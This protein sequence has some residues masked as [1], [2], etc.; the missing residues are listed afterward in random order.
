MSLRSRISC[1]LRETLIGRSFTFAK[2]DTELQILQY[3]PLQSRRINF[4][5][6]NHS[7]LFN[8]RYSPWGRLNAECHIHIREFSPPFL[9]LFHSRFPFRTL[10]SQGTGLDL[11][12]RP[13]E[14]LCIF[15]TARI[16]RNAQCASGSSKKCIN[17]K[18]EF[19]V[20]LDQSTENLR[21]PAELAIPH[22][23]KKYFFFSVCIFFFALV[24][25]KGRGQVRWFPLTKDTVDTRMKKGKEK[26][27]GNKNIHPSPEGEDSLI[28]IFWREFSRFHCYRLWVEFSGEKLESRYKFNEEKA[29]T[30]IVSSLNRSSLAKGTFEISLRIVLNAGR[31]E[32]IFG[33]RHG[34]R[35]HDEYGS[36]RIKVQG[37]WAWD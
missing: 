32:A 6:G 17:S 21:I 3:Y 29:I 7:A 10:L 30:F 1:T 13:C 12:A 9:R 20:S 11:L 33:Y 24:W 5:S 16:R 36:C 31:A 37:V 15:A 34:E 4:G 18:R 22:R 2:R 35:N 28:L 19:S 25:N 8:M 23:K 14:G 26:N 27:R